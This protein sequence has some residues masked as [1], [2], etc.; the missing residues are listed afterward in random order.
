[1]VRELPSPNYDWTDPEFAGIMIMYLIFGC[2]YA[3]HHML[4]QWVISSWTND[5]VML[6]RYA[7]LFKHTR[8][9]RETVGGELRYVGIKVERPVDRQKRCETGAR[10]SLDQN[11]TV[12]LVAVLHFFQ[13]GAA[14]ERGLRGDL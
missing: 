6:A 3:L 13:F 10:Q 12:F 5:P 8:G 11:A 7:G 14:V 1:M 2:L 4:V 9:E